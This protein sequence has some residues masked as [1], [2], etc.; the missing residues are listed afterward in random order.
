MTEPLPPPLQADSPVTLPDG[1][2]VPRYRP[3]EVGGGSFTIN[4]ERAPE[5]IR[6]LRR[7]EAELRS[8]KEE[9]LSLGRVQPPTRDLVSQDA[10]T[11][12]GAAAV[13]GPGSLVQALDQGLQHLG[14]MIEAVET[15][16][17]DYEASDDRARA[18]LT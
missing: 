9:A 10:A 8:I 12:L 5:A 6:E 11:V 15:A 2:S 4:L 3:P 1:T 13:G 7:A 17:R 16:L 14:A 18:G